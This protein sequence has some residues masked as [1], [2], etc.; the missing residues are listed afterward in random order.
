MELSQLFSS[1]PQTRSRANAQHSF[2]LE[3]PPARPS[4]QTPFGSVPAAQIS[5]LSAMTARHSP[6]NLDP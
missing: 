3:S 6:S 1:S 2:S 4:T 5:P